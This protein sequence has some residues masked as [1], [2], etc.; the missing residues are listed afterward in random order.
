MR[1]L[2]EHHRKCHE[3]ILR[4]SK[5]GELAGSESVVPHGGKAIAHERELSALDLGERRRQRRHHRVLDT[6]ERPHACQVSPK[7]S[8]MLLMLLRWMK[9]PCLVG[10]SLR[11]NAAGND[12][13]L[14]KVKLI[15]MTSALPVSVRA[16]DD[17]QSI[18]VELKVYKLSSLEHS[19]SVNGMANRG[20]WLRMTR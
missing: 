18:S 16:A 2:A 19:E 8:R 15:S 5:T 9:S 3:L 7:W 1:K 4:Q 13:K 14:V 10:K 12:V 6:E 11:T 20:Q 17:G